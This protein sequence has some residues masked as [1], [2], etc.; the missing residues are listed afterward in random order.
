MNR[1]APD[2]LT[3]DFRLKRCSNPQNPIFTWRS[4]TPAAVTPSKLKRWTGTDFNPVS[5][6]VNQRAGRGGRGFSGS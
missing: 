2:W 3:G 4:C 6:S 1:Y 5:W